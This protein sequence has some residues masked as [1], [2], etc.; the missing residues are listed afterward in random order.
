MKN[1]V[2]KVIDVSCKM[3]S[4][5]SILVIGE[6]K[7][8][9]I[10][11]GM[12]Y[13]AQELIENIKRVLDSGRSLDY[14][15]ISHSHYDHI[16]AIPY[17]RQTWPELK[18]LGAAHAQH[19]LLRENALHTIKELSN[20][21]AKYY[22]IEET[23][24][25]D[26]HLMKVDLIISEQD[27]VDLGGIDIKVLETPGHTKC[28]LA[29]LIDDTILLASETTGVLKPSGDIYPVFIISYEQT[30]DSIEKCQ[31]IPHK[32]VI[33]PH[34]G[35]LDEEKSK[36]YWENCMSAT[37]KCADFILERF[38]KGY[39]EDKIFDEYKDVYF[40]EMIRLN[41]PEAAFNINTKA[42]IKA[43]IKVVT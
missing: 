11:C 29:F 18:V 28:S 7:V 31:K 17:L 22:G 2:D 21:A 10:D 20:Q 23:V 15:F 33:S 37:K 9:L 35:I 16:G 25:Y 41:Q 42:M 40:D 14:I 30:I 32:Y 36:H 13:C 39:S 26:N 4:S 34:Y 12:A 3:G 5:S 27:K 1:S 6:E 38:K 24:D 8:A 19:I 43:V